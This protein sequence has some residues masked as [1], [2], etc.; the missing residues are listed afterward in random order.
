MRAF[1]RLL[2]FVL[3]AAP[4]LAFAQQFGEKVTVTYVEVP[5]TVIG[6]D[7]APVR[8]L[9]KEN[10]EVYDDNAKRR[11]DS[12]DAIDFAA[13]EGAKAISPLNPASRRN[14]LLLFD[15]S[16]SSPVTVGRAQ[17][18]ARNFIARS[19]GRR[20]LVAIAST[21]V[22]R[23]FRF[24]TA[25]TSDREL[26]MAAIA[27]PRSFRAFDPLQISN[28]PFVNPDSN[29]AASTRQEEAES[30]ASEIAA[31]F[32]R[33]NAKLDD[34]YRRQRVKKQVEILAT[35]AH[36]LQKLAGRKHIVLLSEGFDPRLVQGRGVQESAEQFQENSDISNGEVWKVD[37]DKRY[38]N[39]ATQHSIDIMAEEFRRA[40]V[41]LH[42][43]DIQ[44]VRVQNSVREGASVNS[45]DGLF[46]LAG[47]T[48][49]TVFKNSNNI[50]DD[51]D[52]LTR[53]HEVVYVLGFQAP[54]GRAGEF[55]ALKVKLVNVPGGARV[56][57]RGGY[58]DAGSESIVERSLSTAEIILNDLPQTDIAVDAIATPFPTLHAKSQVPVILEIRGEDLR[59]SAKNN[60][61]TTDIFVYAFDE[62]G[63]VRDSLFQR[64][65]LDMTKVGERLGESGVKYY[66][67]LSLAPGKYAIKTLVRTAE[68]EKKGFRRLDVIVPEDGDVAVVQPLFFEQ[69]GDWIM[70]KGSDKAKA[71]YPFVLDGESFI[72][73]ARASLKKGEPRLFTV[74]VYNAQP[75]EL[76]W[77]TA[78]VA[79][80]VSQSKP[81]GTDVTK[82]VFAL[83][84]VPQGAHELG[85]T[86]RK[87]GSADERKVS[88]PIVVQ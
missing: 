70:V 44:G 9:T 48:G 83:E 4:S 74:F 47:A 73:A 84:S 57:H 43:V 11:V 82:L 75:D 53:Q 65:T 71:G 69:P 63:V 25:F 21:D 60:V 29:S 51:F 55:H 58:Y 12:F 6:R 41:V 1:T 64:M 50:N 52:R 67:T 27:D 49:G 59:A 78:P 56:Q 45:N 30:V 13:A 23:G 18:A 54:I 39:A 15:L 88:V 61:A 20:D 16:F 2:L 35:V 14:F 22:D 26:L 46:L 81:D 87:K 85:V 77:E 62:D 68:S 36:S 37:S 32:A 10:F 3:V 28:N 7:G 17:Q 42:A 19:I 80:L 86:I 38:G 24:L 72:P 8:G 66:G 5:V 34:S 79:K 31:D 76:T 33:N 40:D